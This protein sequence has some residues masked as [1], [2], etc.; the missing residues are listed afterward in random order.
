MSSDLNSGEV[1]LLQDAKNLVSAYRTKFLNEI[2]AH[3]VSADNVKAILQ[4]DNCAGIR[5]YHGH[6][7]K[8]GQ[9]TLVLV[10]VDNDGKDM[11]SGIIM[12]RLKPCPLFCD[13]TSELF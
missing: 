2:K 1:I 3:Y 9:Q 6:D 4:Q 10:G 11:T 8:S 7:D 5:M 12:D 13:I